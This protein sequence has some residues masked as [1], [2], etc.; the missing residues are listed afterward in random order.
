MTSSRSLLESLHFILV[1]EI[2][3]N[4]TIVRDSQTI[5]TLLGHA[6]LLFP[7]QLAPIVDDPIIASADIFFVTSPVLPVHLAVGIV[8]L[9]EKA[10]DDPLDAFVPL[11]IGVL[12]SLQFDGKV[13]GGAIKVIAVHCLIPI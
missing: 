6:A 3:E 7:T 9:N 4:H 5:V 2:K 13:V 12:Y 1:E 8:R 11:R 10:F